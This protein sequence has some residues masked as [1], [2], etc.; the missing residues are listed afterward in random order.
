MATYSLTIN[1]DQE[2]VIELN[3][4]RYT[5]CCLLSS[6]SK[7]GFPLSW[8][9]LNE[10]LN[11]I[12][13]Q[14]T[15]TLSAYITSSKIIDNTSIYIPQ[16]ET[17]SNFNYSSNSAKIAATYKIKLAQ[18]MLIEEYG[19]ISIDNTNATP[20]VAIENN[21]STNYTSGIGIMNSTGQYYGISAESLYGNQNIHLS[22]N[23]S[24]FVMF[25]PLEI[26][27]NTVLKIADQKGMLINFLN[28]ENNTRA[29]SYNINTGWD[30]K[31]A[32]W[33]SK[34]PAGTDL[35]ELLIT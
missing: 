8:L 2:T 7:S 4:N 17:L 28:T 13:I 35:Q 12:Q 31:N 34:Y 33:A 5:L 19:K 32:N 1:L 11:T 16:P 27:V 20:T 22:P 10:F 29:V 9:V 30:A 18:R 21:T 6:Q 14:W 25:T 24:I 3:K 23:T 15:D 26:K